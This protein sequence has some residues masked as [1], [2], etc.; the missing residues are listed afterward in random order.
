[1]GITRIS[2]LEAAKLIRSREI[3]SLEIVD[4]ILRHADDLVGTVNAFITV[5]AEG[6]RRAAAAADELADQDRWLGPLHGVPFSVK[7][8]L[9][10]SGVR[11][12]YGSRAFADNI[13]DRDVVAVARIKSAGGV[14]LGKTATSELAASLQTRSTLNGITR[15]PWDLDRSAGGSSGGA[16][17]A[18]AAGLAPLA[19]ST[20]GAGSARVPASVCGVLGLKPTLGRVPHETWPFHYSN[21][22]SVSINTRSPGD[23]ALMLRI[24]EGPTTADPWSA[25]PA[26]APPLAGVTSMLY[27]Q[28]PC[29]RRPDTAISE[30]VQKTLA[31]LSEGGIYIDAVD[32]DPTHFDPAMV[33]GILAPNLAA[34]VRSMTEEQRALLEDPLRR[35]TSPEYRPDAVALQQLEIER[36]LLHD[37]VERLLH[38][39]DIIVTPTVIADPPPA[40]AVIDAEWWTHLA[41]ANFTGHPAIS[42]PCGFSEAGIPIGMHLVGQWDADLRLLQMASRIHELHRWTDLWPTSTTAPG[43]W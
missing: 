16:G 2:A 18:T 10:T 42:V 24:I 26:L 37:R 23:A 9:D 28:A 14:L 17:A 40:D 39:Y 8:L 5:D 11:T 41:V 6:A 38:R 43:T 15:N 1:M 12:T 27:I 4:A 20:D 36:S 3:S 35:L 32:D 31:G 7:Y 25:R 19:L 29:S 33:S 22:S 30:A 21:N 34:R 13:P